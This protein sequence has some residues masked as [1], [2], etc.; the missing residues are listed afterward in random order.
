MLKE[1]KNG[2]LVIDIR[3][4][5]KEG[6]YNKEDA[7]WIDEFYN[8]ELTM[9]DYYFNQING[10]MYLVNYRT[11]RVYDFSN[12]YINIL[13]DLKLELKENNYTLKLFPLSKKDGNSLMKDLEN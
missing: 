5:I 9:S 3:K 10:Y 7:Q 11:N 4:D 12:C 6:Y 2:N 13:D 8:Q 1:F